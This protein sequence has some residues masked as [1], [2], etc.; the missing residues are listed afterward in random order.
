MDLQSI[1]FDHSGNP[2]EKILYSS[3][4]SPLGTPQQRLTLWFYFRINIMEPAEG[5]EP[6][7]G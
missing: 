6:T 1:P 2:P 5:F 4:S 7:T 3:G